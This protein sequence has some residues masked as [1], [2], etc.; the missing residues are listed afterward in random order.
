MLNTALIYKD[1][2]PRLKQHESLYKIVPS[3]EDWA[4]TKMI[5]DKLEMFYH[6]TIFFSGTKYPTANLY[7]KCICQ[8]RLALNEWV[9]SEHSYM[10]AMTIKMIAKFEK[11]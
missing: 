3:E 9:E 5:I 1:V 6:V 4:K 7:F 2:F 11:Y 8:I 10:A